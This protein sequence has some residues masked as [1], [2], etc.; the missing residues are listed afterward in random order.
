MKH[1]TSQLEWHGQRLAECRR[2]EVEYPGVA[3]RLVTQEAKRVALQNTLAAVV[4]EMVILVAWRRSF[5]DAETR[6]RTLAREL[7]GKRREFNVLEDSLQLCV[8]W[9][10]LLGQAGALIALVEAKDGTGG[11][12]RGGGGGGG[13]ARKVKKN[14]LLEEESVTEVTEHIAQVSEARS[15]LMELEREEEV[16]QAKQQRRQVAESSMQPRQL[17]ETL[18]SAAPDMLMRQKELLQLAGGEDDGSDKDEDEDDDEDEG[19]VWLSLPVSKAIHRRGDS[20]FFEPRLFSRLI[21]S[22]PHFFLQPPSLK[23]S[24]RGILGCYGACW[25]RLHTR[26]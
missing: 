12:G 22:P 18:T 21:A 13:R 9:R 11:G 3:L 10:E 7:E 16:L 5:D 26:V 15:M 8:Q 20:H 19:V 1:V 14:F 24:T 2:C 23:V 17:E 25:R 4:S 6:S